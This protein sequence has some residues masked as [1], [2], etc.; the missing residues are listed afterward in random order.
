MCLVM[1]SLLICILKRCFIYLQV[2]IADSVCRTSEM[3][4]ALPQLLQRLHC[5]FSFFLFPQIHVQIA[6]FPFPVQETNKARFHKSDQGKQINE[7]WSTELLWTERLWVK[8]RGDTKYKNFVT[9]ISVGKAQGQIA[10]FSH[11]F[12]T[13]FLLVHSF[14]PAHNTGTKPAE[15]QCHVNDIFTTILKGNF[16]EYLRMY[17]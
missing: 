9:K 10:Q 7:Q 8:S 2:L 3:L 13:F 6:A 12:I 5:T 14:L 4:F 1:F 15:C 11:H 17:I 16:S